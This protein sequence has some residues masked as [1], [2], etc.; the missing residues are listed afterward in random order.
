MEEDE[1]ITPEQFDEQLDELLKVTKSVLGSKANEYASEHNRYHNFVLSRN[2]LQMASASRISIPQMIL[3][4]ATK[5]STSC[6]DII[7]A[8]TAKRKLRRAFIDEKFGDL[9]NY[10]FLLWIFIRT[11]YSEGE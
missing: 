11:K 4:L 9:I 2:V 3:A 7:R 6:M 10:L 5:H 8:V 1:I